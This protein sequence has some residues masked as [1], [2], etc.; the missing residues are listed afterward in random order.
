MSL[1]DCSS[2]QYKFVLNDH[3]ILYVLNVY[4]FSMSKDW[5]ASYYMPGYELVWEILDSSK[6]NILYPIPD[7]KDFK[8]FIDFEN[9]KPE[10][11]YEFQSEPK[12]FKLDSIQP[13]STFDTTDIPNIYSYM[14]EIAPLPIK[15]FDNK[16]LW[17][18]V[19]GILLLIIIIIIIV[20]VLYFY[21]KNSFSKSQ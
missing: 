9:G 18:I 4:G 3:D 13:H 1:N 6:K 2:I 21:K 12:T 19:G 17:Y 11:S 7:L 20:L 14:C 15:K 5:I 16:K 10:A 8:V